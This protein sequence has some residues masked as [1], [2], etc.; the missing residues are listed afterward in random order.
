VP[1]KRKTIFLLLLKYICI[2]LGYSWTKKTNFW[3][4]PPLQ[5]FLLLLFNGSQYV[6]AKYDH[7]Q[8]AS[9]KKEVRSTQGRGGSPSKKTL[10]TKNNTITCDQRNYTLSCA[11]PENIIYMTIGEYKISIF[12]NTPYH[13]RIGKSSLFVKSAQHQLYSKEYKIVCITTIHC[14]SEQN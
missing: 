7:T 2:Q 10:R 9:P 14:C 1:E 13:N 11:K 3:L 6:W 4:E 8:Y 12:Q 5:K